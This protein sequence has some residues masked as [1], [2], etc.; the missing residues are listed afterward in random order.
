M[1]NL[2]GIRLIARRRLGYNSSIYRFA[3]TI[4][5]FVSIVG[6]DGF[7]TYYRL[8]KLQRSRTIEPQKVTLRS[9]NHPFFVRPHTS[10]IRIITDNIIREE[11]GQFEVSQYGD[12]H[13]MIDAGAYIGDTT[14]YFLSRFP[15]L[16]VIALEPNLPAYQMLVR[17]LSP[18]YP[19]AIP[20]QMGLWGEDKIMKFSG[21]ATAAR[22]SEIGNDI[23]C[24]SIPSLMKQHSIPRLNILKMDIEGAEE[25]VFAANSEGWLKNTDIIIIEFHG[26]SNEVKITSHLEQHGFRG[27]RF[28]S[29]WYFERTGT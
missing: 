12:I 10:D 15:D 16:K 28:R 14:A 9:V 13:W 7:N 24:S 5:D 21:R 27:R 11:Y 17:N 23:V 3:S 6:K 2:E 26:A 8:K 19:R 29:V 22:I 4:V 20:L 25:N 1:L 18:Y